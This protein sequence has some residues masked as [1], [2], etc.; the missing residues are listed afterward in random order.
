VTAYKYLIGSGNL[1]PI[2]SCTQYIYCT[3]RKR[4]RY[5]NGGPHPDY[6]SL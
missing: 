1:E 6:I 4:K 5:T 2:K 3:D